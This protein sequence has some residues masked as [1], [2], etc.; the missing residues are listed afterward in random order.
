MIKLDKDQFK[1]LSSIM[2]DIGQVTLASSVV[3]FVFG[4]DKIPPTVL[5]SGLIITLGCWV[6]SIIF[7]KRRK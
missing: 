6:M 4:F 1:V 5:L 3:P 2:A 7:A